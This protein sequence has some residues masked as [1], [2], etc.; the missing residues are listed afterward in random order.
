MTIDS[1]ISAI[2]ASLY[3]CAL[4]QAEWASTLARA[5]ALVGAHSGLLALPTYDADSGYLIDAIDW[6]VDAA[7]A[8][9]LAREL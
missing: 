2:R 6:N 3:E 1:E 8:S 7:A 9:S 4:G 5:G